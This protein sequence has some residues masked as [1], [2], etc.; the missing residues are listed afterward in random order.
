MDKRLECEVEAVAD[1]PDLAVALDV[2]LGAEDEVER[3]REA[4]QTKGIDEPARRAEAKKRRGRSDA[5]RG[6]PRQDVR[7]HV[8]D[9]AQQPTKRVIVSQS[10]TS[11]RSAFAP[12][13]L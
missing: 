12:A 3:E 8:K 6:H 13:A 7:R 11:P 1:G 5:G 9:H 10:R 4:D 2:L